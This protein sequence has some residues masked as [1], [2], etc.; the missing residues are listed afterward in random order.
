MLDQSF[1]LKLA[2]IKLSLLDSWIW[3][4]ILYLISFAYFFQSVV[5]TTKR[6]MTT[7]TALVIVKATQIPFNFHPNPKSNVKQRMSGIPAK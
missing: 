3:L 2:S 5:T 4:S 7:R 6:K 1:Y